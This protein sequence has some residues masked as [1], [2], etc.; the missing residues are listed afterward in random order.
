VTNKEYLKD[1]QKGELL[2]IAFNNCFRLGFFKKF[3]LNKALYYH[4]VLAINW[5]INRSTYPLKGW[6]VTTAFVGRVLRVDR[7][8]LT[9]K[10]IELVDKAYN[11]LKNKEE[12]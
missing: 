12:L 11:Y 7:Q 5:H 10:Q 4:D 8:Q 3:G 6:R 2:A 1:L 9:D